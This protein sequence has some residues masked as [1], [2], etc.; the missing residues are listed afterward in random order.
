MG[1]NLRSPTIVNRTRT[2]LAALATLVLFT[3]S[4]AQTL[5]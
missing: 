3:A 5:Q 2:L 1:R 4:D